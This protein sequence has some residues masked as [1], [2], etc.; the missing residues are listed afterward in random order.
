[1]NKNK[2]QLKIYFANGDYLLT[3]FNGSVAEAE[4]Y[5]L[6]KVFNIGTVLDDM[7]QCIR[8]KILNGF[9]LHGDASC[10]GFR[11]TYP[12]YGTH[13]YLNGKIIIKTDLEMK[14]DEQYR[15]SRLKQVLNNLCKPILN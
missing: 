14:E 5:Y 15:N 10:Y 6:N 7:Q 11:M 2:L 8:V 1:M 4:K 9:F 13:K 3:E 12:H